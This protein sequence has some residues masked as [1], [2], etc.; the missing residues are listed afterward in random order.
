MNYFLP[1]LIT[2]MVPLDLEIISSNL[3]L[4]GSGDIRGH[5]NE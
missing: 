1:G 4:K 3:V 2:E 5:R